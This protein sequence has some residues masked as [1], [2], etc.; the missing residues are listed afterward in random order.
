MISP[1]SHLR[2]FIARAPFGLRA[3][4]CLMIL[5]LSMA[6]SLSS[7]LHKHEQAQEDH[8]HHAVLDHDAAPP[9]L[10]ADDLPPTLHFHDA[11]VAG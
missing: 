9:T 11:P 5:S 1:I 7:E 4:V 3:L 6:G 8:H 10:D 2:R